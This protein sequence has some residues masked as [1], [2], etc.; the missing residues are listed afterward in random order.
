MGLGAWVENNEVTTGDCGGDLTSN[1]ATLTGDVQ[2]ET[3]RIEQALLENKINI[4]PNPA[5]KTIHIIT[6]EK[7]DELKVYNVNGNLVLNKF[8]HREQIDVSHLYSGIY[9]LKM[10]SASSYSLKKVVINK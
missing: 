1:N 5:S 10:K 7:I 8:G 4:Y 3:L 6:N 2:D 9:F